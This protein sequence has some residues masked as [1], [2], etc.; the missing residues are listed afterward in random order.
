MLAKIRKIW[1][2]RN[3]F[4]LIELLVVIAVIALLASLLLPALSK[5]R[6]MGRRIKC[7]SNLRQFGLALSMYVQD[8]DGY[9]FQGDGSYAW[10]NWAAGN[11]TFNELYMG[12]KDLHQRGTV[13]DCPTGTEGWRSW[14]NPPDYVDYGY[15]KDLN[16]IRE[17]RLSGHE[18]TT[19]TFFDS[20]RYVLDASGPGLCY[21]ANAATGQGIQWCHNS[22]ANFLFYDGHVKWDIQDNVADSWFRGW[23]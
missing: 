12:D 10:T 9:L 4:T 16:L 13:F 15:N 17:S 3:S 14:E 23:Q 7:I 21:W 20:R 1:G 18:T 11:T 5:A 22:G 2:T 6:E 8:Y 19:V